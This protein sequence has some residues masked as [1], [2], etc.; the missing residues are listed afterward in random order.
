MMVGR[1]RLGSVVRG[2]GGCL[3][4]GRIYHPVLPGVAAA[5]CSRSRRVSSSTIELPPSSSSQ[6]R[7]VLLLPP[8]AALVAVSCCLLL[9]A[10][11]KKE[12]NTKP[13]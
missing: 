9:L 6:R 5:R 7:L 11:A 2:G 13:L 10:A 8:P 4:A 1:R 12:T 3:V